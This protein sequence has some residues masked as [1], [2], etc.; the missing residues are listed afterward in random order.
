MW[1]VGCVGPMRVGHGA[2]EGVCP[3][4]TRDRTY[5]DGVRVGH[6]GGKSEPGEKAGAG[7]RTRERAGRERE[8]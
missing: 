5:F 1:F 6:F 4:L 7:E 2:Q 3:T 8:E